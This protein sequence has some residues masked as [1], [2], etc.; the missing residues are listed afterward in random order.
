VGTRDVDLRTG[1][2]VWSDTQFRILGYEPTPGGEAKSRMWVDRTHPDDRVRI[3]E[4]K[5]RP[6][7]D[8]SVY[9]LE[10]RVCRPG[11]ESRAWVEVFGRFHYDEAGE[12]VRY[13]GVCFDI[14]PRKDMERELLEITARRQQA[15]GQELH[16][17]VGQDLTAQGLMAQTLAQR[18]PEEGTERPI[19]TRLVTMR[20]RAGL[21]GGALDI[22][23]AEQGGTIVPLTLPWGTGHGE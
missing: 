13:V 20:Y 19:A 11:Q 4:A 6:R 14:T 17:G 22:R 23:P 10:Y 2:E 9:H 16:D 21:I 15:F 8:G 12:A 7:Q 1:R 3:L 5:A 18:L